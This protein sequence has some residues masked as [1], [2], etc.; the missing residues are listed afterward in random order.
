[1]A[2]L[3]S[4]H[5]TVRTFCDGGEDH[6]VNRSHDRPPESTKLLPH[7]YYLHTTKN[8]HLIFSSI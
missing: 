6:N 1:M 8:L 5:A 3:I 4:R 2:H 7:L